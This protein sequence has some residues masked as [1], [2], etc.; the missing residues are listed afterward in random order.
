MSRNFKIIT[1][2]ELR[3]ILNKHAERIAKNIKAGEKEIAE[4]GIE[5][6]PTLDEVLKKASKGPKK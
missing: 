6:L 2:F 1:E 4:K 3:K 5:N